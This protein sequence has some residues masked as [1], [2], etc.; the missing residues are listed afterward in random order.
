M[1]PCRAGAFLISVISFPLFI[2]LV[3]EIENNQTKKKL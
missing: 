2:T 1:K 3:M